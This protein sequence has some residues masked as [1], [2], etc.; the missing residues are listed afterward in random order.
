MSAN[1]THETADSMVDLAARKGITRT[2]VL[3]RSIA[4][5]KFLQDAIDR[6]AKVLIKDG[7]D[8]SELVLI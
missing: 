7:N 6:G 3:R 1:I 4:T 2:E 8:I 5:Q